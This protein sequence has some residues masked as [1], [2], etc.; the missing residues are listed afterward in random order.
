MGRPVRRR[1]RPAE[2]R[3]SDERAEARTSNERAELRRVEISHSDDP[4]TVESGQ[5]GAADPVATG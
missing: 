4:H 2:G 5:Q 1:H 3:T